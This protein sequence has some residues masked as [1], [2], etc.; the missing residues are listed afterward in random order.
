[1]AL[2]P[3]MIRLFAILVI[4]IYADQFLRWQTRAR[5]VSGTLH[6]PRDDN[7]DDYYT[8]GAPVIAWH[9][10]DDSLDH[11]W[12]IKSVPDE[13]CIYTIQNTVGGTY[14]SLSGH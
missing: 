12:L 1:M 14:M 2:G 9:A 11:L 13:T 4:H 8:L 10:S 6:T 3:S 7:D 5:T